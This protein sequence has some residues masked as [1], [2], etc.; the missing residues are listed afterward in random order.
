MAWSSRLNVADFDHKELFTFIRDNDKLD[1]VVAVVL[2]DQEVSGKMFLELSEKDLKELF[3]TLGQRKK[4]EKF[5]EECQLQAAA[6][7]RS[8]LYSIMHYIMLNNFDFE[9]HVSYIP[10]ACIKLI[11]FMLALLQLAC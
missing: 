9:L 7:S 2:R 3:P 4:V 6:V 1:K 8:C 11:S 10:I 5:L